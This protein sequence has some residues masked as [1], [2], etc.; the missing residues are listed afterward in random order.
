MASSISGYSNYSVSYIPSTT[1]SSAISGTSDSSDA[2]K[3]GGHHH[4]GGGGGLYSALVSALSQ[5]G[6]TL[7]TSS[8]STSS[9]SKHRAN[10]PF[11]LSNLN[12]TH[13]GK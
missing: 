7:D 8:S 6:I 5:A 13:F 9:S 12:N 1:S 2:Q 11:C 3:T 10:A 4:H